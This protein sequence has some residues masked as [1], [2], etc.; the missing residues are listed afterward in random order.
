MAFYEF[1]EPNEIAYANT[2]QYVNLGVDDGAG[3]PVFGV[4]DITVNA[5]SG[6]RAA[7]VAIESLTVKVNLQDS[8]PGGN[9]Y[10]LIQ[11]ELS[12]FVRPLLNYNIVYSGG[13]ADIV[14]DDAIWCS[15]TAEIGGQTYNSDVYLF[16]DGYGL[17]SDGVNAGATGASITNNPFWSWSASINATVNSANGGDI[18]VPVYVG[19]NHGGTVDRINTSAGVQTFAAGPSGLNWSVGVTNVNSSTQIRYL[20]V[21]S[22][23]VNFISLGVFDSGAIGN[24]RAV[25]DIFRFDSDCFRSQ[26]G[27]LYF[28]NRNGTINSMPI[29]GRI[30]QQIRTTRDKFSNN[31]TNNITLQYDAQEHLKKSYRTQSFREWTMNTGLITSSFNSALFDLATSKRHWLFF[32]GELY[33]VNPTAA[34]LELLTIDFDRPTNLELKFE[35][36][37]PYASTVL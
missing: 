19:Y 35:D 17:Y 23:V 1:L 37:N 11:F 29:N 4:A 24:Y 26:G 14:G 27:M 28:I 8:D 6:N 32:R 21:N 36:A 3:N 31:T 13:A 5:W 9:D 7:P 33:P 30:D 2:K 15:F 20:S 34:T 10:G 25:G 22:D 18:L 16:V 12:D